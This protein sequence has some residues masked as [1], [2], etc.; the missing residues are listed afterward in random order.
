MFL[1]FWLEIGIEALLTKAFSCSSSSKGR[2]DPKTE[3]Q[4]RKDGGKAVPERYIPRFIAQTHPKSSVF[5][6][7]CLRCATKAQPHD[8]IACARAVGGCGR[9]CRALPSRFTSPC[10]R[11]HQLQP[12][13]NISATRLTRCVMKCLTHRVCRRSPRLNHSWRS[14]HDPRSHG[15]FYKSDTVRLFLRLASPEE[16]RKVEEMGNFWVAPI[17]WKTTS[18]K[19]KIIIITTTRINNSSNNAD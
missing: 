13:Q 14:L 15:G 1:L 10:W 18:Y 19:L 16:A 11:H 17:V 2:N 3:K 6:P 8:F 5:T 4:S 7:S 12:G 9:V